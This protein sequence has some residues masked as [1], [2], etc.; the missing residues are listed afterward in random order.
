M[1]AVFI[2]G[3]SIS[4]KVSF[5]PCCGRST[6]R[7]QTSGWTLPHT[8]KIS[9]ILPRERLMSGHKQCQAR[10]AQISYKKSQALF[11]DDRSWKWLFIFV[12]SCTDKYDKSQRSS[13]DL[14]S[15]HHPSSCSHK[16]CKELCI[17]VRLAGQSSDSHQK[18]VVVIGDWLPGEATLAG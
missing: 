6:W 11:Q 1:K 10:S 16:T 7:G 18:V 5:R 8:G 15:L 4:T 2:W 14:S 17:S 12:N 9:L 13:C 3:W